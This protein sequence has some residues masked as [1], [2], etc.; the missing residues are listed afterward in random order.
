MCAS[1]CTSVNMCAQVCTS[2]HMQVCKSVHMC[3]HMCTCMCTYVDRW[4]RV[5]MHQ[6]A[7]V[8]TCMHNKPYTCVCGD[9]GSFG[10]IHTSMQVEPQSWEGWVIVGTF[11]PVCIVYHSNLKTKNSHIGGFQLVEHSDARNTS[12]QQYVHNLCLA[13]QHIFALA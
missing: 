5:C 10:I 7:Q 13:H 11:P 3:A 9:M 6:C 4:T 1:V 12:G 2:V 8:C